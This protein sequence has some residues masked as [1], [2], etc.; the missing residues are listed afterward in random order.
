[1]EASNWNPTVVAAAI[2][3]SGVVISAGVAYTAASRSVYVNAITAARIRWIENVRKL[4]AEHKDKCLQVAFDRS[5]DIALERDG[6]FLLVKVHEELRLTLG[7][8]PI[9]KN[10]IRLSSLCA[11]KHDFS[12]AK[13]YIKLLGLHTQY[14][15]DSEW[16]RVKAEAEY[17][18][19]FVS[20]F[21]S[22]KYLRKYKL[23]CEGIGSFPGCEIGS[24][25]VP[26]LP[27]DQGKPEQ[28]DEV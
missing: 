6:A 18:L 25:K 10:I 20:S 19:P 1:M 5:K 8:G 28:V 2:A 21:D 22:H 12:D 4:I 26:L 17:R 11:N 7:Q 14:L 24:F 9:E 15:L 3:L 16:K 23:F 27:K 13:R